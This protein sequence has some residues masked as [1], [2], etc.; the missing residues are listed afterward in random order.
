MTRKPNPSAIPCPVCG[1]LLRLVTNSRHSK[2]DKDGY[3]RRRIECG[4]GH[5]YNTYERPALA[6][7]RHDHLAG[8]IRK[9]KDLVE[10]L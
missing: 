2:A 1:C 5:R 10:Y 3:I 4:K 9:L 6:W 7:E 8:T